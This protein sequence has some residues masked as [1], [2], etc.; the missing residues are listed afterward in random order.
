MT[1]TNLKETLKRAVCDY[2]DG[3]RPV[4]YALADYLHDIPE[5]S[6]QEVKAASYIRRLT[7]KYGFKFEPV[8]TRVFK[9]AFTA[10][11]GDCG[12][13]IGFMAEYDA[14]PQ[15]GHGCGHNL[16]AMMSIGA[17]LA[18]DRAAG[19][20]ARTVVYGCAAEE[21]TGAKLYMADA[22]M[23]DDTA[24]AL[25]IHP[26]SRT[27]IGGTS[28]ATHP[29]E[30]TFIGKAAHV[31]DPDYHG[32]NALDALVDFYGR[33][34]L[35]QNTFTGKTI[36]GTII[37]EGGTA[38]NIVPDRASLHATIR[39][40]STDYLEN[41]MLPQ[42]KELAREVAKQ[43][44]A[45]VQMRHYEPLYKNLLS[46]KVLDNYYEDNFRQLGENYT[47]L[48]DDYA[49]GSTDVGNVSHVTRT[50]QPTI[51]IGSDIFA[52]TKEFA[53]AA[54]SNFGREQAVKGAKA[55]AMTAVDVF[56]EK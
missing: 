33:F 55:I 27:S 21:T 43:H 20:R 9:T 4:L 51:C 48:P 3:L 16:I 10:S 25:I 17:A 13:K 8:L 12:K 11:K 28:Y 49:D 35:L 37:T 34:K 50:C 44:G 29:L 31:A 52:H 19:D 47:L 22:G 54:G 39:S 32:I 6:T 14:L 45:K 2:I 40:M 5:V 26:D 46:D 42:I 36:I 15:I 56:L 38:P 53:C 30:I 1:N 7:E 41:N 24:A 18:F 23:F